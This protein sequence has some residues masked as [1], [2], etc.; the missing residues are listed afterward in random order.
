MHSKQIA[1]RD[2]KA[3]PWTPHLVTARIVSSQRAPQPCSTVDG[4]QA[5]AKARNDLQLGCAH[6]ADAARLARWALGAGVARGA[7]GAERARR[8]ESSG[9]RHALHSRLALL[10]M[11]QFECVSNTW[12]GPMSL[13]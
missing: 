12:R 13:T 5:E 7:G 3:A 4:R 10:S 2:A 6:W 1:C 8:A 9:A 11:R